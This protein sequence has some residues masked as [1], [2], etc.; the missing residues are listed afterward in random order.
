MRSRVSLSFGFALALTVAACG[1]TALLDPPAPGGECGHADASDCLVASSK[2]R[3]L[4]PGVS[5]ADL[6]AAAGGNTAFALDLYQQLRVTS[7]NLFYS[8]FSL[9]E[10]LAMTFAGARGETAA[11]MATALH[12]DLPGGRLHPAFDALDLAL[13]SRGKGAAGADG[14]GFRLTLANALWGQ[15]GFNFEAPFLDTLAQSYGATMHV[16]DFVGDTGGARTLINDWIAARTGDRIQDLLAPGSLTRQTRMV[17]TNAVYFNAA[18]ET[19]F[20]PEATHR[21]DF[22]RRDGS[23]VAVDTMSATQKLLYGEGADHAAVVLPYDGGELSMALILPPRGELDAFEATL[24]PARLTALLG[25]MSTHT[26]SITLPRF[27]IASSFS[28]ADQLGRLGMPIPFTDAA[29]FTGIRRQGGL[30]LSAVVHKAFL[31]VNE[32]GTEAAAATGVLL[33]GYSLQIPPPPPAEIHLDHPFLLLIRDNA[34][35]TILFLGR[36]EDPSI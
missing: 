16:A 8:P 15:S 14:Q 34:T 11:Q 33:E 9:S 17:L 26:V 32:A 24:T 5:D 36:I 21:A 35:G 29:D 27:E 23:R 13:A 19:P 20:N 4:D 2:R 3:V 30:S 10:A 6:E 18:W 25:G 31:D 22:T 12:F 7:G 1:A 28:L